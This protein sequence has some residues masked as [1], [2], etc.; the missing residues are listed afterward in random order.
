VDDS[1][2]GAGSD[3]YTYRGERE[4]KKGAGPG[5]DLGRGETD[6]GMDQVVKEEMREEEMM[7]RN[8]NARVAWRNPGGLDSRRRP[9]H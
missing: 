2:C 9:G 4:G 1:E 7:E 6:D 5:R 8:D 3:C